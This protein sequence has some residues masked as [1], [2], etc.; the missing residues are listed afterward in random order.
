MKLDKGWYNT[1]LNLTYSTRDILGHIKYLE[2]LIKD[3]YR[4]TEFVKAHQ[5]KLHG[6][7]YLFWNGKEFSQY[8]GAILDGKGWMLKMGSKSDLI[9]KVLPPGRLTLGLLFSQLNIPEGW[10]NLASF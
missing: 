4:D 1:G 8:F 7:L 3:P 9:E 2:E 10:S 5:P 6:T